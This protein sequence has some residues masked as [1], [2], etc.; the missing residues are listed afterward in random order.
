MKATKN[1]VLLAVVAL[2]LTAV[3]ATTS[4]DDRTA[5]PAPAVDVPATTAPAPA[6]DVPTTVDPADLE[7][8]AW[9]AQTDSPE[10]DCDFQCFK[11]F[12]ECRQSATS[13]A[14]Y[15]EC[16][17]EYDLCLIEECGHCI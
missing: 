17:D 14:T 13:T 4:A 12:T 10:D 1:L 15:E 11:K 5:D 3:A 6:V 7:G 2:A 8:A 16:L 9:T